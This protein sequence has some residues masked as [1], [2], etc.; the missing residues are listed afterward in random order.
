MEANWRPRRLRR[1]Q[2]VAAV[3]ED[4]KSLAGIPHALPSSRLLT[5]L[6]ILRSE[7]APLQLEDIDGVTHRCHIVDKV[8]REFMVRAGANGTGPRYS[9]AISLTLSEAFTVSGQPWD[10]GIRWTEFHWG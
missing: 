6:D 1:W 10:S 2:L 5:R 4:T 7:T 9:R 8:E 3:E